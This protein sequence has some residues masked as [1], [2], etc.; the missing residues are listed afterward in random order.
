MIIYVESCFNRR[1]LFLFP[2]HIFVNESEIYINVDI[3]SVMSEIRT[4]VIT[5]LVNIILVTNNAR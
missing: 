2:Y 5:H 3:F 1:G 4:D